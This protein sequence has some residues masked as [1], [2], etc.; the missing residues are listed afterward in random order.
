MSPDLPGAAS[1]SDYEVIFD[2]T[3]K[4]YK[5]KTG[6]DLASDPLLRRL[7]SCNSPDSVLSLLR[8]QVPGFDQSVSGNSN[9]RL[10]K[11]VNPAVNV[12]CTFA[13]TISGAV[14]LAYPPAGVIF[15]GI[16]SL[17]S[18]VLAVG[19]SQA[20]LVDLFERIENFF[21]RLGIYIDIPPTAEMTDIIVKVMVDVLLILALVTREIKQGK[22]IGRKVRYRGR[23]ATARQT[24]AGGKS[25]GGCARSEGHAWCG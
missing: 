22:I 21:I 4:A 12:L 17:L 19:A 11:W 3:L 9:E 15:T 20:A 13:S 10:T 24:N 6:K 1:S 23:I 8:L 14:S 18:A 25:D 5:K 2:N 16:A 7:E